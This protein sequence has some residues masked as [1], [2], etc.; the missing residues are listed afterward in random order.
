MKAHVFA[1]VSSLMSPVL[2][3]DTASA[4][5]KALPSVDMAKSLTGLLAVLAVI[6]TLAWLLRRFGSFSRLAPGS[7]RVLAAVSLGSRERVVLLQAGGKQLVLG[8]APGRVETLCILENS[9]IIPVE[10][11]MPSAGASFAERLHELT[12]RR[13]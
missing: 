11:G 9:E 1:V 4:V 2:L 3:A 6:F 13:S 7:F 8:V 12:G 5:P 10:S